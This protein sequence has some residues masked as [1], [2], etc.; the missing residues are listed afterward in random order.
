MVIFLQDETIFKRVNLFAIEIVM[1]WLP[2]KQIQPSPRFALLKPLTIS[3][4][5]RF[6]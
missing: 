4:I 2:R 3:F 6:S 5:I 1:H